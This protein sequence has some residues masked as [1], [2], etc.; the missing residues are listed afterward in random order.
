MV[1]VSFC[2]IEL[3]DP[4]TTELHCATK[5][6]LFNPCITIDIQILFT[7]VVCYFLVSLFKHFLQVWYQ[8]HSVRSNL[9]IYLI[10]SWA[11]QPNFPIPSLQLIF[12][13]CLQM[14]FVIFQTFSSSL[15]SMS[16]CQIELTD[17]FTTKL[18]CAAKFWL[19]FN[20]CITID[21]QILFTKMFFVIF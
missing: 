7:N 16:F 12:R 2:Q 13:F 15:A 9:L 4:F 17:P 5:L 14:C 10:L 19:F 11:V 6:W 1:S 18:R 8:C 20:P 21:I 3:T